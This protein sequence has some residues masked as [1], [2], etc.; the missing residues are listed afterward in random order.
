MNSEISGLNEKKHQKKERLKQLQEDCETLDRNIREKR[1]ASVGQT[2][3]KNDLE[4]E[5][6]E[7]ESRQKQYVE[8]VEDL[9]REVKSLDFQKQEELSKVTELKSK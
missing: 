1:S 7:L 5:I 3:K 6:R 8:Q 2:T 9:A 4:K